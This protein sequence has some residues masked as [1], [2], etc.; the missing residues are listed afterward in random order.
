MY[1]N[2]NGNDTM[3][4]SE[5]YFGSF[6]DSF[7]IFPICTKG[8]NEILKKLYNLLVNKANKL[9]RNSAE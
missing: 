4:V 1:K 2:L 6:N 3:S 7:S 8:V 5:I 9:L